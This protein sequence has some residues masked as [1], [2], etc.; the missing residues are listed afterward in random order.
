MQTIDFIRTGLET[1]RNLTL[2]L[3]D[4]M[5]DAPFTQPTA[6]GG[7]HPLWV[8]GHLTF[9]EAALVEN[10]MLGN[11]NPLSEWQEFFAQSTQPSV[12]ADRYPSWD[13]VRQK[14]DEVR[15]RTLSVLSEFSDADLNN[16]SKNCP[17]GREQMLG[18]LA[19]CLLVLTLHPAMHRGQVADARRMLGREPLFA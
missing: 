5:R 6:K 11:D 19:S 15:A 12:E 14:S 18:T 2:S 8:L 16:P 17:P 7:N 13:D 3:I 1:S 9:V 10:V 4:D